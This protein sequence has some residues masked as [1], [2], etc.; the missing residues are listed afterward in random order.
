MNRFD[1]L[2]E[3]EKEFK[4]LFKKYGTLDDDL[5]KFKKI[6][7][8]TPT[9]I[10]KNFV[11]VYSSQTVKIVKARMACRALRDRSLR[12]IY[13]Y[14]EQERRIDFIEIYFKGEKENEDLERIKEYLKNQNSTRHPI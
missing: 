14:F 4:R 11:T 2:A 7:I 8:T 10:G 5:E 12:I 3:F 1:A 6:L 9:G 13:S